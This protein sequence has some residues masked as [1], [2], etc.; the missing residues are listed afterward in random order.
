MT[1]HQGGGFLYTFRARD[2]GRCPLRAHCVSPG[3]RAKGVYY[4]PDLHAGRPRGIRAAMR[5]RWAVER[6]FGEEKVWHRFDRLRYNG[7]ER[8]AIQAYLTAIVVDAKKMARRVA[9]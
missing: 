4:R 3:R 2:C 1:P 7:R 8:A 5:L 6:V 9:A